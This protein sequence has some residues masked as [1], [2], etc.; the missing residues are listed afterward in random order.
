MVNCDSIQG[1]TRVS[2]KGSIWGLFGVRGFGLLG[3]RAGVL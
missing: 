1:T 3:F 2:F